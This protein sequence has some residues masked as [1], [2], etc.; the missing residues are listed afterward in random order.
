TGNA[1]NQGTRATTDRPNDASAAESLAGAFDARARRIGSDATYVSLSTEPRAP[2]GS[3]RFDTANEALDRKRAPQLSHI[4]CGATG[5]PISS[6]PAGPSSNNSRRELQHRIPVTRRAARAEHLLDKR[7]SQLR[8]ADA[9]GID[10]VQV[11]RA[12]TDDLSSRNSFLQFLN[13]FGV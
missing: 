4:M 5:S 2:R 3:H 12:G 10:D 7:V 9:V 6:R 8:S 13:G 1:A 11:A